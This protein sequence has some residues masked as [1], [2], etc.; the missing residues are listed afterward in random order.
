M[1]YLAAP[2]THKHKEVEQIRV[3]QVTYVAACL[4]E[5][6]QHVFSPL[7]H[8]HQLAIKRP[9]PTDFNFWGEQCERQLKMCDRV[10]VLMLDGY[11]SSTGVKAEV[12]QARSLG[13]QIDFVEFGDFI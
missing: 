5:K 10:M 4:M 12:G 6:G 2:Y 13:M 3:E 7:T 11:T 9:L 8:G 1:I